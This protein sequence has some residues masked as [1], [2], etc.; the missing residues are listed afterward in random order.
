M[1]CESLNRGCHGKTSMSLCTYWRQSRLWPFKLKA[2]PTMIN[3][4]PRHNSS[5][6]SMKTLQREGQDTSNIG[7][8]SI[9]LTS[10]PSKEDERPLGDQRITRRQTQ[11][12]SSNEDTNEHTTARY[13]EERSV[14]VWTGVAIWKRQ[15]QAMLTGGCLGCGHSNQRSNR[16]R[17]F[18]SEPQNQTIYQW[19][20]Y[21]EKDTID[22]LE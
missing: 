6:T 1:I 13:N 19:K 21:K 14:R 3:Q 9:K 18:K 4:N 11:W 8:D 17:S 12:K 16:Q 2:K 7:E 5:N 10:W 15:G 22:M 20:R